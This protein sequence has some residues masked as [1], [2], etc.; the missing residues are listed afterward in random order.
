MP[1]AL[2]VLINFTVNYL[3]LLAC[4]RL[5]LHVPSLIRTLLAAG[6]GAIHTMICLLPG[7][8]IFG[9]ILFRLIILVLMGMVAFG[10]G[11]LH[12][13]QWATFFLLCLAFEGA[14]G[15]GTL[16]VV[17][18]I[19]MLFFLFRKGRGQ[20]TTVPVSIS[21]QGRDV[22]LTALR[23]TGNRL[24]DP[25]S[26]S[27]VMVIGAEAARRLTG[28]TKEQLKNPLESLGTISGLR[29]IPYKAVGSSGFLLGMKLTKVQIGSWK[30]SH[31]VA[32]APEGLEDRGSYQALI[33]GS[34]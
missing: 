5:C 16:A 3:L 29:L 13:R 21:Y 7:C 2:T 26:G 30:G 28:L 11:K 20:G 34:V 17:C 1:I 4:A 24:R 25:V 10:F 6:V 33:G 22:S 27:S 14:T 8:W 12:L 32:F 31:I 18:G 23:D 9:N 19:L 15:K